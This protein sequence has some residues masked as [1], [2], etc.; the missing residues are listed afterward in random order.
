[1]ATV[2]AGAGE[3]SLFYDFFGEDNIAN[4]AATRALGPFIV[5]GQGSE[6]NDDAGVP[7]LDSG[8]NGVGV[9]TSTNET[10]HTTLVGT[11]CAL[12]V[13][14]MGPIVLE[15]RVR[16][17]TDLLTKETFFG[18][19]DVDPDTL[20]LQTDILTGASSVI[21]LTGTAFVGFY[22]SA[23][24]TDTNDWHAVYNGGT[25]TGETV[26]P[27]IDLDTPAVIGDWQILRLEIDPNGTTRWFVDGGLKKTLAGATSTTADFGVV[28]GVESKGGNEE[29]L[30][31]DYLLVEANR[32]WTV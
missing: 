19:T 5:G 4:T 18:L 6:V 20:S 1:M 21:T 8:L 2:Q 24:L 28:L 12:D 10:D 13:A 7:T 25:E 29:T 11:P 16:F 15:A 23:E 27:N 31:V 32:D 22:Q 30:D 17:G 26:S 3:I 9:I 14:L